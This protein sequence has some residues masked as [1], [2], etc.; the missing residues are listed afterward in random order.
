MAQPGDA[1]PRRGAG[2]RRLPTPPNSVISA[3]VTVA[4]V[5]G[6][7]PEPQGA[8]SRGAV[9]RSCPPTLEYPR[10]TVLPLQSILSLP[11]RLPFFQSTK[12][13][14]SAPRPFRGRLLSSRGTVPSQRLSVSP[15]IPLT[16][17][18]FPFTTP[19]NT[20]EAPSAPLLPRDAQA[21][22][23]S[24]GSPTLKPPSPAA[25]AEARL[26]GAALAP[27]CGPRGSLRPRSLPWQKR[28][29][30]GAG[31]LVR[32]PIRALSLRGDVG[33]PGS[34]SLSTPPQLRK[35]LNYSPSSQSPPSPRLA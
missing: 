11:L 27:G 21:W 18:K 15:R 30:R 3:G 8:G 23:P 2:R 10:P 31:V 17:L 29:E 19:P 5:A 13:P 24:G 22:R 34:P 16:P 35:P 28:G 14:S 12:L 6:T 1:G 20:P 33:T 9:P 4:P 25:R 7:S 32:D 26:A